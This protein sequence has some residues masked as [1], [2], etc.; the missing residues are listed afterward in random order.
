MTK[1]SR[2]SQNLGFL[3][4]LFLSYFSAWING[5]RMPN[6]WSINYFIPSFYDGF[7][8]RSLV[9]TLLMPLES[10]RFQY[11]T[12]ATLQIG[13][14]I[15]LNVLI[16]SFCKNLRW[17]RKWIWPLFLIGP[18][19]GY[20]F[21]L[22]GYI[23]QLLYLIFL[24]AILCKSRIFGA[25]LI[26]A[27]LFIHE[28]ALF[29]IIPLYIGYLMIRKHAILEAAMIG[30]LSL[31]IFLV[32]YLF[33]QTVSEPT[34]SQ[35]LHLAKSKANYAVRLDY[36]DVF[37][38]Q[39]LGGRF[40]WYY[41]PREITDLLLIAPLWLIAGLAFA[42]ASINKGERLLF[43]LTG[44]VVAFCPILLGAFGWDCHRWI[45]LSLLSSTICLLIAPEP[46][47]RLL[48]WSILTYLAFNFFG[49]FDYFDNYSPR[50]HSYQQSIEFLR[51]EFMQLLKS[52]P[53]R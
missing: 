34:L 39:F 33:F 48:F 53:W 25:I 16:I 12:I 6:L 7:Y 4:A 50:L 32:L 15:L 27:S 11:L 49:F 43:F 24:I 42:R 18:A 28:M 10:W 46:S 2:A 19:G 21:H 22:V 26:V 1:L 51:A 45:F 3:I 9:G 35:F 23:D 5:F 8:R 31:A 20:F 14:F 29:T 52:T 44:F 30:F 17:G 37:S 47:P 38:N 40:H 41:T 36:Y 13:I